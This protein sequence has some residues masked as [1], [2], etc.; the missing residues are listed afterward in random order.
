MDVPVYWSSISAQP[1]ALNLLAGYNSGYAYGIN[2]NGNIVG[3]C[4]KNNKSIPVYWDSISAQPK[5]LS[6]R[7]GTTLYS[8]GSAYGLNNNGIIVG[9]FI[10]GV[11]RIPVYWPSFSAQPQLLST[12]NPAIECFNTNE[13]GLKTH[14]ITDNNFIVG[15]SICDSSP[16]G[17]VYW[18]TLTADPKLFP[19][20][21][22]P[23]T[24]NVTNN[25]LDEY[26]ING[27]SNPTLTIKKGQT[28]TFN[29]DALGHPFWIKTDT[30]TGTG[31][32][33]NTGVTNNGTANGTI[34]FVVS[35]DAPDTLYYN[36]QY[37]SSMAGTINVTHG[38][39]LY[40][41]YGV[42]NNGATVGNYLIEQGDAFLIKP[43]YW[44]SYTVVEQDL[45]YTN[46]FNQWFAN[47]I[48]NTNVIVG[49]SSNSGLGKSSPV[50]WSSLSATPQFLSSILGVFTSDDAVAIGIN[51]NGVI[52]GYLTAI[53][54]LSNICFPAGTPVRTDQG[55]VPINQL[56]PAKHTINRA[57]IQHITQTRTLDKYLISFP[58]G[59]IRPHLPSQ[60]TVMTKDHQI[61]FNG[62]M[63][64]AH[65]F[66]T[67]SKDIKKVTYTGETLYNVLLATPGKMIV[68]DLVCETLHPENIIAKLYTQTYTD[69]ERTDLVMQLNESLTTRNLD[70]YKNTVKQL[71]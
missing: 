42:N 53:T 1:K 15:S 69:E 17:A 6:L 36:C 40:Q 4:T 22:A 19:T 66:L 28:Y 18:S 65:R 46:A 32:A 68:N 70:M 13:N 43:V 35:T 9:S 49:R 16:G 41:A 5:A 8:D 67:Y 48:N 23:N 25:G 20:S 44:S 62:C 57:P 38:N 7:L 31:N 27:M 61:E 34:T 60:H 47:G 2:N 52:V 29:I 39:N 12:N 63:V 50:Y 14:G 30:S 37:H 54:A 11:K 10:S 26:I 45:P 51:D 64:P 3:S 58:P 56:D 71:K 21:F 55:T 24:F 33:Y 59:S